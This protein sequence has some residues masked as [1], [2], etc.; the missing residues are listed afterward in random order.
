M[1]ISIALRISFFSSLLLFINCEVFAQTARISSLESELAVSS[2]TVK[3]NILEELSF[4]YWD[5]DIEKAYQYALDG[6]RLSEPLDYKKGIA[7]ANTHIGLY[8]YFKGDFDKAHAYYKRAIDGIGA[9]IY[10][11]YPSYTL[12]R[13]ANLYRVQS[14]FDSSLLFYQRS[15]ESIPEDAREESSAT[16]YH[17]L[18]VTFLEM[19]QYDSAKR[20]LFRSFRLR[21][22]TGDS[23]QT[24]SSLKELGHLYLK[25]GKFDSSFHYL[26]KALQIGERNNIP[27]IQIYYSIYNGELELEKGN[28]SK[29]IESIKSSLSQLNNYNF[30]PLR[31]KSLYVLGNIYTEI[32]EYDGA[33]DNL[34]K[35]ESLNA[36]LGNL[37]QQAQINFTLGYVYYYQK[38][39]EKFKEVAYL[40]KSQ[41]QEINLIRQEAACNNLLG[42][43]ELLLKNYDASAQFFDEGMATYRALNYTKGIAAILFNKSYIYLEQGETERVIQIQLE[44]LELEK[45]I[46]NVSGLIISYNELGRLLLETGDLQKAEEYLLIAQELLTQHPSPSYQADNNLYLSEYYYKKSD[47][48]KAY[49]YLSLSKQN[50]DSVFSQISLTKSLQLS[51]IHELEKKELEIQGL[52]SERRTKNIELALQQSQLKQQRLVIYFG[53]LAIIF[54]VIFSYFL[55]RS[56]KKQKSTQQELIKAEKRAS[57]GMLIAGLDHEI[58]NPLNFIKGGV[59]ALR[60]GQKTWTEDQLKLLGIIEE[61]V[62]RTSKILKALNRF[63]KQ[64]KSLFQAC[65]LNRIMQRTL[66]SLEI[67]IPENV[68]ISVVESNSVVFA[69][70]NAEELIQLFTE[71]IKNSI[72]SINDSGTVEIK[73]L[74]GKSKCTI[75]VIDSGVGIDQKN[76]RSLENPFFTTKDP[77][78]GKGLG[79]YIVDYI[80]NDHNGKISFQP[81]INGGT[82]A[83]VSLPKPK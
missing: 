40:A 61:G 64:K 15:L 56:I 57:L 51:A 36:P 66:A 53:S 17:N 54:F 79:L 29:A 45:E 47:F 82:I 77:D 50:S 7:W 27:E 60:L 8:Y 4:D 22:A 58:N 1:M 30:L 19:E 44:A 34:L 32:G 6:L 3:I 65:D 41:F 75:K 63:Q 31:I 52:N 81:G 16:V 76:L 80:L 33:I 18:G 38:N 14:Q 49:N 28:Y 42:L 2:D 73:I 25:M 74:D 39:P 78:V 67:P 5:Y 72:Q 9:N 55:Y 26:N 62:N 37:K 70:G 43:I 46:D 23:I 68:D 13:I 24:A 83:S 20:N 21:N 69:E 10:P 11:K 35:A 59:G 71:L 48:K 12:S